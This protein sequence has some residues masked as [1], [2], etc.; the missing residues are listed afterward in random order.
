MDTI[1]LGGIVLVFLLV[2]LVST[3]AEIFLTILA[4]MIAVIAVFLALL[5]SSCLTSGVLA[6]GR[7]Q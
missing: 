2:A 6:G 4:L 1:F 7:A 3:D 5:L